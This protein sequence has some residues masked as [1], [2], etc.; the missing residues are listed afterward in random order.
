MVSIR[1]KISS[2]ASGNG[3]LSFSPSAFPYQD[4]PFKYRGGDFHYPQRALVT[5]IHFKQDKIK[6]PPCSRV[7]RI[8]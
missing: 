1:S 3:I 6:K 4:D 8:I 2:G 7:A 5:R